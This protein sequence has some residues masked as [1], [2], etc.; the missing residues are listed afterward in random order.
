MPRRKPTLTVVE[1]ESGSLEEAIEHYLEH[2]AALRHSPR[3]LDIYGRTLRGIL[4]PFCEREGVRSLAELTDRH[5][6]RLGNELLTVGN[7]FAGG[8]MRTRPLSPASVHAYMRGING[9]LGWARKRGEEVDPRAKAPL[10]KLGRRMPDTLD[11]EEIRAMEDAAVTE[12]DKLII[13]LFAD[14]GIRLG[15]LLGL[16]ASD[17]V[18]RRKGEWQLKVRGKGSKERFVPLRPSLRMRLSRYAARG[19]REATS[20][21]IFVSLRAR[22]ASRGGGY[23]PLTASG[24][25]QMI[26]TVAAQVPVRKEGGVH[27]HLFRH[28]F[29]THA[30]RSG[31]NPL[32]LQQILGHETLD[33]I[34]NVYSHLTPTDAHQ[35]VMRML[36]EED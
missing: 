23:A 26:R 7:A 5:L 31:M 2:N 29:A 4:L 33:M 9:F 18:E 30:L 28:S 19:R 1:S 14:T 16:R 20:E 24:V 27:P 34:T 10:P 21:R 11:R 17:I 3:T 35:A 22:A 8:G 6:D 36:A 25:Q 12:R 13:R 15:E 32:Q